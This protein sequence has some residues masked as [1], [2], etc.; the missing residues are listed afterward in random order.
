MKVGDL[1]LSKDR[2]AGEDTVHKVLFVKSDFRGLW[3]QIDEDDTNQ[4][5]KCWFDSKLYEVVNEA[6]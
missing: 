2:L 3:I 1:V 4:Y 5:E 6:D